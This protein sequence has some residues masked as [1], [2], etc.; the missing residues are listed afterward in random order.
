MN[1]GA[2][3]PV[4]IGAGLDQ[5]LHTFMPLEHGGRREG[6]PILTPHLRAIAVVHLD[7]PG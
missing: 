2:Q 5:Q 6:A 1:P 7:A 4:H 3:L